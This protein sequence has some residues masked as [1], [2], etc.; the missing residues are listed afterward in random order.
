[1]ITRLRDEGP[2]DFGTVRAAT[3]KDSEGSPLHLPQCDH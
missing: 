1:M 2:K 3:F